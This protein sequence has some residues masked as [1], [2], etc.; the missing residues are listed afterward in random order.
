M[1]LARPLVLATTNEGK[2]QEFRRLLDPLGIELRSLQ[3]FGPIP[4]IEEDGATF[5]ENAVKKAR[6]T[7]KY[8]GLPALADDSGLTVKALG[9]SRGCFPPVTPERAPRMP[10]TAASCWRR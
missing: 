10:R 3:D 2:L 6:L 4:L 7:A 9:V 1:K 8:L 5:E